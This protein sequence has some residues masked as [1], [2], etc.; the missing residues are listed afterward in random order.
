MARLGDFNGDGV[1]DFAIGAPL[2]NVRS[3]Q[4]AVVYGRTGFTSVGLP[5]ATNTRALVIGADPVLNRTQLGVAVAGVGHFYSVTTGTTLVA[6]ATGLGAPTSTSSNEGRIYSFHG[7]G[8]GAPINASSADSIR[9]G[10]AKGAEIGTS[11]SNLGPVTNGL[12]AVGVG[13]TS[14]TLTVPGASG[15]GYVLSGTVA[16]GPLANLLVIYK[17]GGVNAAGQIFFGGGLP[18]SD[19]VVSMIGGDSKPD[20]GISGSNGVAID[21]FDG[22]TVSALVSPVDSTSAAAVHVPLPSGWSGTPLG[23]QSLIKDI[24][25]DG[26]PDFALGDLFGTVPGR[27]AVFW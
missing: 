4:I 15:T 21:I 27:V 13:N 25:G 2:F 10:P 8:P 12:A 5:D 9:I 20:I 18:G 22:T 1:D 16:T 23:Q 14:D 17:S 3:G 19:A 11:L 24:N 26:Y 7:R 6:S